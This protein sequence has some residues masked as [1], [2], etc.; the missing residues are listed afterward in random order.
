MRLLGLV[1]LAIG[2][3]LCVSIVWATIGFLMMGFGLICLMIAERQ[4]Q[5][6]PKPD[7]PDSA[8]LLNSDTVPAM[9]GRA[10]RQRPIVQLEP[11]FANIAVDAYAPTPAAPLDPP[12]YVTD[13]RASPPIGD[14][15]RAVGISE[16]LARTPWRA[17]P[18]SEF[19]RIRVPRVSREIVRNEPE[20]QD[21]ADPIKDSIEQDPGAPP[22]PVLSPSAAPSAT[23]AAPLITVVPP[24][25]REELEPVTE[26]L[27]PATA[28]TEP[29][30]E[31][32][33]R[34]VLFD[35]EDDLADMFSKFDLGNDAK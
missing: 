9:T 10:A 15:S 26:E 30:A 7:T 20:F 22:P 8:T 18:S 2:F 21:F 35:D 29:K 5:H 4:R 23:T 13:T 16:R 27:R 6:V 14:T 28:H 24:P 1:L 32:A 19:D 33:E 31:D 3:L 12:I 34:A 17:K 25:A 11:S